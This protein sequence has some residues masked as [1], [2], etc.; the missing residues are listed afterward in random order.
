MNHNDAVRSN[1]VARY[2]LGEVGNA[3]LEHY[4]AHFLECSVC[5]GEIRAG[6]G[7]IETLRALLAS[8]TALVVQSHRPRRCRL[9]NRIY[10]T[11]RS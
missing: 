8:P 9:L 7:L 5:A 2:L 10:G 4:E 1:A 3:E 6:R 11:R